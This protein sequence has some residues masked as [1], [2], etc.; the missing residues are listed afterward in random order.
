M[1]SESIDFKDLADHQFKQFGSVQHR[2]DAN[3]FHLSGEYIWETSH[4]SNYIIVYQ[5]QREG[6][7]YSEFLTNTIKI[8]SNAQVISSLIF[9]N[10]SY[11]IVAFRKSGL[12]LVDLK[13][14][15]KQIITRESIW[16]IT[17][18][19]FVD[20]T[21]YVLKLYSN[22]LLRFK[23]KTN[24]CWKKEKATEMSTY[25]PSTQL[26]NR[27]VFCNDHIHFY[28]AVNNQ[29]YRFNPNS[30][31]VVASSE[32]KIRN[33][34][35]DFTDNAMLVLV[36]K[37][38]TSVIL[39]KSHSQI[40]IVTKENEWRKMKIPNENNSFITSVAPLKRISY[41]SA[42][43]I[44]LNKI[45]KF[46]SEVWIWVLVKDKH[47]ENMRS[48]FMKDEIKTV[49]ENGADFI[50]KTFEDLFKKPIE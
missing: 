28:N 23:L 35:K 6:D 41:A 24:K 15:V 47:S 13:G 37:Y 34:D 31:E 2:P 14:N 25:L 19:N 11:L 43:I 16:S 10:N 21:I 48:Y 3:Q 33:V 42:P 5:P 27:I 20:D 36:D 32:V 39:N 29:I 7:I 1:I 30:E 18:V 45:I 40:D 46:G 49:F 44:N 8:N 17:D 12:Y 22:E 26:N 50:S 38:G 4:K 9:I